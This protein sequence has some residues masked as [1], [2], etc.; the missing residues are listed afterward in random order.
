MKK[1]VLAFVAAATLTAC[2]TPTPLT[3]KLWMVTK[4]NNNN[5]ITGRLFELDVATPTTD[6]EIAQVQ[7]SATNNALDMFDIAWNGTNLYGVHAGNKFYRVRTDTGKAI[8]IKT[9]DESVNALAFDNDGQL[10]GMGDNLFKLSKDTGTMTKINTAPLTYF[11]S[12]DIVFSSDNKLF[13]SA[14]VSG[15]NDKWVR[16]DTTNGATTLVGD[17]GKKDVWGMARI[18]NTIYGGTLAG[19]LL[20][21]NAS[22]GATTVLRTLP[23]NIGSLNSPHSSRK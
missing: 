3:T 4:D 16:V 20:T 8:F 10:W 12:G 13:V 23:V 11:P 14:G 5:N 7:D 9:L 17:M 19:E 22:T 6:R 21:I 1:I 15:E 18:G 2:P